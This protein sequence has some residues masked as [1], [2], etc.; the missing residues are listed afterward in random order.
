MVLS[1]NHPSTLH[2]ACIP[3][4][5]PRSQGEGVFDTDDEEMMTTF[6]DM[7]GPILMESTLMQGM[8]KDEGGW[9]G[10]PRAAYLCH[11]SHVMPPPSASH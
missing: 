7:A 3:P 6:L 1:A 11:L 2:A 10:S 4:S 5:L 9:G 8:S